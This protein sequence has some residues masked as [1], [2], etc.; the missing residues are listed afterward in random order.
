M[1]SNLK[2][3]C[4]NHFNVYLKLTQYYKSTVT[5]PQF[6]KMNKRPEQI[7]PQRRLQM[8]NNPMKKCSISYVITEL[9]IKATMRYPYTSIRMVKL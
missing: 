2:Y 6:F 1:E 9:Q 8:S 3:I 7:L 5:I 4:Q